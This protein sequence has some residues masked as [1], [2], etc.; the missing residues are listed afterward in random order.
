M[1]DPL[2][3]SIVQLKSIKILRASNTL[4]TDLL[5]EFIQTVEVLNLNLLEVNRTLV[6]DNKIKE[7]LEKRGLNLHII[8][9]CSTYWA[10]NDKGLRHPLVSIHT[11]PQLA[12]G[13]KV[14]KLD[15]KNPVVAYEK[16]KNENKPKHA[17][18]VKKIV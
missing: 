5:L 9:A 16:F 2:C 3:I 15:D 10:N 1:N 14:K 17:M 18:Y 11:V 7:T 13:Q 12:K 8:K 6:K 4:V